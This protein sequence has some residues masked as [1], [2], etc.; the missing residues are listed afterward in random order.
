MLLQNRS[1][2]QEAALALVKSGAAVD[3]KDRYGQ[4]VLELACRAVLPELVELLLKRGALEKAEHRNRTLSILAFCYG[5]DDVLE[6]SV[7]IAQ[8]LVRKWCRC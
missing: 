1:V 4:T 6:N 2:D 8:Q 5:S 7:R 3:A